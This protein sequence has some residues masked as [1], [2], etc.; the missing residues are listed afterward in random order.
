MA[1]RP[2][3]PE[4]R[5]AV[6]LLQSQAVSRF[7]STRKVEMS[8]RFAYVHTEMS[9]EDMAITTRIANARLGQDGVK[10]LPGPRKS[11]D[12]A[13]AGPVHPLS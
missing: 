10:R 2:V 3:P 7:G 9:A 4:S 13:S 8:G 5:V 1:Q 11:I 6:R 12:D